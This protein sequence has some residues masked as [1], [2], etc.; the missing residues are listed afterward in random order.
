MVLSGIWPDR[1]GPHLAQPGMHGLT[2]GGASLTRP[3]STISFCRLVDVVTKSRMACQA[4]NTAQGWADFPRRTLQPGGPAS[5][6]PSSGLC[7]N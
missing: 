6:S 5:H 7:R 4:Q 1:E 2:R 3:L